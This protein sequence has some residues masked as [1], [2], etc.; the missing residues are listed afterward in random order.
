MMI[1]MIYSFALCIFNVT[2]FAQPHFNFHHRRWHQTSL[3]LKTKRRKSRKWKRQIQSLK[4][5]RSHLPRFNTRRKPCWKK[6]RSWRMLILRKPSK[7]KDLE[8]EWRDIEGI[9][10]Y[11]S[12][13]LSLKYQINGGYSLIFRKFSQPLNP[14]DLFVYQCYQ[15]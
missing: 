7:C 12:L 14:L 3:I 8:W 1:M 13:L 9:C 5:L 15:F 6:K 4:A 10:V 2:I 11:N